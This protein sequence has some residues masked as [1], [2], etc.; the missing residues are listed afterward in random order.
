MPTHASHH[1]DHCIASQLTLCISRTSFTK[2]FINCVHLAASSRWHYHCY[3]PSHHTCSA[4]ITPFSHLLYSHQNSCKISATRTRPGPNSQDFLTRSDVVSMPW[5]TFLNGAYGLIQLP[6][7]VH[8]QVFY[9]TLAGSVRVPFIR[10][11]SE[12]NVITMPWLWTF[13]DLL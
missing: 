10:D 6:L 5:G 13:W 12:L 4:P 3:H 9:K 1:A 11:G 7:A 8:H 2:F